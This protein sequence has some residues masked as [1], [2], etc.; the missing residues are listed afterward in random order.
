MKNRII[1][2]GHLCLDITPIFPNRKGSL[3]DI[4]EPGKLIHMDGVNVHTGGCVANVG[5]ALKKLGA[6][7][8]LI[9]KVGDDAF[10]DIVVNFLE[11]NK[12]NG[13]VVAH[14][15]ETSYSVVIAPPGVDRIFLHC[16]GENDRF[17]SSDVSDEALKEAKLF[18]F[19]YPPLMLSTYAN[20]GAELVAMFKRAISHGVTTSL[21]MAAVDASSTAGKANWKN[22]LQKVLPYVD[23]FLPSVEEIAYML[24]KNLYEDWQARANGKDVTEIVKEDEVAAL[25]ETLIKMGAKVVVLKCGAK[26]MYW[27]TADKSAFKKSTFNPDIWADKHGFEKSYKPEK[28]LSGTGAG[29]SSIAAYLL[30]VLNGDSPE[31]CIQMATAEG[32]CCVEAYDALSGLR[33]LPELKKRIS[34]GWEKNR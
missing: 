22:I 28:V 31:E 11:E 2:A 8:N 4:L 14:G 29:D 19:G 33:T 16:S 9:G 12:V 25:S 7:V 34:S 23:L 21:D 10:G 17:Y 15:G 20:D 26:G 13:T 32:A 27:H 1:V 3:G 24:D 30:S 18:H 6:D 5:L